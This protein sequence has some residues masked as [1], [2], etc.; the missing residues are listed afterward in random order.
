MRYSDEVNSFDFYN[1]DGSFSGRCTVA[2]SGTHRIILS[3]VQEGSEF[4]LEASEDGDSLIGIMSANK[5]NSQWDANLISLADINRISKDK[6]APQPVS[7]LTQYIRDFGEGTKS[8]QIGENASFIHLRANENDAK[9]T[10]GSHEPG[11]IFV[12]NA[13]K[14]PIITRPGAFL[15]GQKGIEIEQYPFSSKYAK[16]LGYPF[17]QKIYG[18]G[19]FCLEVN[20][21]CPELKPMLPGEEFVVEPQRLIAMTI[22]DDDKSVFISNTW[23]ISGDNGVAVQKAAG[24]KGYLLLKAG[25]LGGLVIISDLS[26]RPKHPH[27]DGGGHH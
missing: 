10:I 2:G 14:A 25:V 16:L 23:N 22:V 15:L 13:S 12:F 6:K 1:N 7:R 11:E 20:S 26:Q 17:W 9:I 3:K 24:S 27:P 8:A 19:F 21:N 5:G 4:F 18:K